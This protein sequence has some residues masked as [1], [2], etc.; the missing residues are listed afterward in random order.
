MIDLNGVGNKVVLLGLM[1]I[2]CCLL[3]RW[4]VELQLGY[5][6]QMLQTNDESQRHSRVQAQ[7]STHHQQQTATENL[8]FR[9]QLRG[10][11]SYLRVCSLVQAEEWIKCVE[12]I[13]KE[14]HSIPDQLQDQVQYIRAFC[15][16]HHGNFTEALDACQRLTEIISKDGVS[17]QVYNLMGCCLRQMGK[18]HMAQQQFRKALASC[19]VIPPLSLFN[20][21]VTYRDLG[22]EDAE[23]KS[24]H[25]LVKAL[26]LDQTADE[27]GDDTFISP[28][29]AWPAVLL[30]PVSWTKRKSNF[31][32]QSFDYWTG[33]YILAKRSHDLNQTDIAVDMFMA[34][35]SDVG[36]LENG[37]LAFDRGSRGNSLLPPLKT[38]YLDAATALLKAGKTQ[39]ALAVCDKLLSKSSLLQ[40]DNIP[41]SSSEMDDDE[42]KRSSRR[43]PFLVPCA[44]PSSE[45]RSKAERSSHP[46]NQGGGDGRDGSIPGCSSG[47]GGHH[48][49]GHGINVGHHGTGMQGQSGSGDTVGRRKR[50]REQNETLAVTGTSSSTLENQV[51]IDSSNSD[52][53]RQEKEED[54]I[55]T[56]HAL[57]LQAHCLFKEHKAEL[58]MTE[59]ECALGILQT[60]IAERVEDGQRIEENEGTDDIS[61][62]KRRRIDS[63]SDGLKIPD[64]IGSSL[65]D[66]QSTQS[67]ILKSIAY[68]LKAS[69]LMSQ[70]QPH[71]AM[72]VVLQSLHC[73]P[74][75]TDSLRTHAV[76]L[77]KLN[78]KGEAVK[79]WSRL[80][81]AKAASGKVHSLSSLYN[82]TCLQR[83]CSNPGE[84]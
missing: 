35:L 14:L 49:L 41:D 5:I 40:H 63:V 73:F 43:F 44:T 7:D 47:S 10:I 51:H 66:S 75:N 30:L 17:V 80:K 79:A 76:I 82:E 24:L 57:I 69:I 6:E 15:L 34:L 70:N 64:N 3:Q 81:E 36:L 19:S 16:Y 31:P 28:S 33:V 39:E 20:L 25:L 27:N 9:M 29:P 38:I 18:P 2:S 74:S 45:E 59:V 8:G 83:P 52:S 23:M 54:E 67:S 62:A 55:Y 53:G 68:Q 50:Q 32:I 26:A 84:A 21:S 56:A 4:S 61:K 12:I 46:V 78:R 77:E 1:W 11:I 71:D 42:T 58:A 60:S 65:F 48:T 72:K 37:S 13:N 22:D